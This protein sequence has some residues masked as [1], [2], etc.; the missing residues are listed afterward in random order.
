MH[1]RRWGGVGMATWNIE[2]TGYWLLPTGPYLIVS[3]M[4]C[5]P[6]TT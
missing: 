5:D 2:K 6:V 4:I 3:V 1:A